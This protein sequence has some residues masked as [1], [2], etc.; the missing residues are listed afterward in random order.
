MLAYI[1][2]R[3]ITL[4]QKSKVCEPAFSTLRRRIS[5]TTQQLSFDT[6]A[7]LRARARSWRSYVQRRYAQFA[8]SRSL[9][10]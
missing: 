3:V 4:G 7:A 8:P 6:R 9:H 5:G 10:S 1:P 2:R